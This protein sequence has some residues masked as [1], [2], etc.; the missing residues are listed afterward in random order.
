MTHKSFGTE[1]RS[2][3]KTKSNFKLRLKLKSK[4]KC[5]YPKAVP[6]AFAYS[7]NG[8]TPFDN[9]L[10]PENDNN[11]GKNRA[12]RGKITALPAEK[13]FATISAE[14][15]AVP[16]LILLPPMKTTAAAGAKTRKISASTV[17]RSSPH[18]AENGRQAKY[19]TRG[20]V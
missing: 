19:R 20:C 6:L 12:R 13:R 15:V 3:F 11:A 17:S 1:P 9:R 10:K 5:K 14:P 8:F 18:S 16:T 7:G 2:D 4:F